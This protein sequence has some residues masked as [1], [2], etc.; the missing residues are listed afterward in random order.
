MPG[1]AGV[2]PRP[3]ARVHDITQLLPQSVLHPGV[4]AE[5]EEHRGQ[6]GW[7]PVQHRAGH[8]SNNQNAFTNGVNSTAQTNMVPT[9][10]SFSNSSLSSSGG[11]MFQGSESSTSMMQ[12]S[13]YFESNNTSF[14]SDSHNSFNTECHCRPNYTCS[15]CF[16]KEMDM[17]I[18]N[19]SL[20][21]EAITIKIVVFIYNVLIFVIN[22][23][24]EIH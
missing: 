15:K 16:Q 6:L 20:L 17:W 24:Y 10:G 23:S 2:P 4:E 3:D 13:T 11:N 1:L 22:I 5:G 12:N 9:S 19:I 18:Y 14:S 21:R 7:Q 8:M